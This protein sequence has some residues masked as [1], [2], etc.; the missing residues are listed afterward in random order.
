MSQ[1]LPIHSSSLCFRAWKCLFLSHMPYSETQALRYSITIV[2]MYAYIH[3]TVSDISLSTEFHW[4]VSSLETLFQFL[5]LKLVSQSYQWLWLAWLG[6]QQRF[7][8]WQTGRQMW[9]ILEA[10]L[11]VQISLAWNPQRVIWPAHPLYF[12][13]HCRIVIAWCEM[14]SFLPG[15]VSDLFPIAVLLLHAAD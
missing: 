4:R 8:Y 5:V 13:L 7:M 3:S 2:I 1:Y 9:L 12:S 11:T 14:S 10:K 15:S 6:S